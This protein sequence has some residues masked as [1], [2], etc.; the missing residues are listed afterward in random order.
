MLHDALAE[1]KLGRGVRAGGDNGSGTRRR[2]RADHGDQD[3]VRDVRIV[4]GQLAVVGNSN[5]VASQC[6][7]NEGLAAAESGT[8]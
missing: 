5:V 6:L 3:W 7:E 1:T 4:I 2:V 8:T